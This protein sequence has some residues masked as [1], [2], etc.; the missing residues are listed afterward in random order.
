MYL[1][2]NAVRA[3]PVHRALRRPDNRTGVDASPRRAPRPGRRRRGGS[4]QSMRAARVPPATPQLAPPDDRARLRSCRGRRSAANT[5]AIRLG[6]TRDPPPRPTRAASVTRPRAMGAASN[7]HSAERWFP[8]DLRDRRIR[9]APQVTREQRRGLAIRN[10]IREEAPQFFRGP[11]ER[12]IPGQ[13]RGAGQR[14][15]HRLEVSGKHC[16]VCILLVEAVPRL[17]PFPRSEHARGEN[18]LPVARAGN[19]RKYARSARR[20]R[21]LRARRYGEAAPA[22]RQRSGA[23][24]MSAKVAAPAALNDGRTFF[25]L[26]PRMQQTWDL[27]GN[28]SGFRG[29]QITLVI[30]RTAFPP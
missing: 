14:G 16:E 15:D 9:Q 4:R 3:R 6:R 24:S 19:H 12:W 26:R 8:R 21:P 29:F 7:A 11:Q 17:R 13:R 2:E 30:L 18:R 20:P 23:R 27:P 1:G 10:D 22:A 28:P 5:R 25:V